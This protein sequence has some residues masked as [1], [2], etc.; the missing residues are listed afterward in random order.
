MYLSQLKVNSSKIR[1]YVLLPGDLGRVM[2][3]GQRLRNF[4]LVGQNR[5]FV[6]G[7]GEY[8]GTPITVC[9]TGIGCPSTAIAV[10]QLIAARA[11]I[12]IRIGTCGGAWQRRIPAGSIIIPTACVRDEGTT[13]EYIPAEFPA[14]AD[15]DIVGRLVSAA[16][17]EKARYFIGIN[18]TH[19]AFYGSLSAIT[20]WGEYLLD[21]R[22]KNQDTPILSSEMECAALF[23]IAA[24]RNVKAAAILAVNAD[25]EPLSFRLAGKSQKVFSEKSSLVTKR[26]VDLAIRVALEAISRGLFK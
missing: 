15:P 12:L 11:Q 3:I 23:V 16:K 13:R 5:E 17:R 6:T 4:K 9:S 18:R 21:N 25:P 22:W 7:V 2:I 20:R 19:D 8:K 14:V 10:E 26:T 1:P 24:L